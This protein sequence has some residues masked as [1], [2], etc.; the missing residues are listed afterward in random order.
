MIK[1][2]LK[3]IRMKEYL[4]NKKQFANFVGIAEIPYGRYEN[5]KIIPSLETALLMSE[6]LNQTVNQI[7][8]IFNDENEGIK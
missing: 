4:M 3:Q 6:K 5:E 7:F 2:T 1:N 8:Y